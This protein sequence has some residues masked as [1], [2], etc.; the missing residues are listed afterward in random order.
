[1]FDFIPVHLATASAEEAEREAYLSEV[2]RHST[3]FGAIG[4]N[5]ADVHIEENLRVALMHRF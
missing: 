2:T 1:M 5:E 4:R 3:E